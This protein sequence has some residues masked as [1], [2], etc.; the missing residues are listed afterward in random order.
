MVENDPNIVPRATFGPGQLGQPGGALFAASSLSEIRA[1]LQG[2]FVGDPIKPIG[3]LTG[4]SNG[5]GPLRKDKKDGLKR[6][7][8]IVKLGK[9]T[10]ADA[11]NHWDVPVDNA[12]KCPFVAG[13]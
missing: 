6:V 4:K 8:G 3:E 5:T 11:E 2:G 1:H 13:K 7:F 10:L 9:E 12:G